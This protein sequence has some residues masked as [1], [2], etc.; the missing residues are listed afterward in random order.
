MIFA[1]APLGII[2]AYLTKKIWAKNITRKQYCWL[3][4]ITAIGSIFPD[5]DLFYY[6][7]FSAT[8]S[9]HE[10]L[11]HGFFIYFVICVVAFLS[12]YFLKKEF[13][14]KA[15]FLFLLGIFSHLIADSISA[16]VIWLAPFSYKMYG[17]A[18]FSWYNKIFGSYFFT[19]NYSLEILFFSLFLSLILHKII[20]SKKIW[21]IITVGLLLTN[22]LLDYGLYY[23][24]L[25]LYRT[26]SEVYYGD[27]D[28]DN[29]INRYDFDLDGDG[30]LNIDDPDI[31]GDGV[32]N[33][34]QLYQQ[35]K[36][37]TGIFYDPTEG[38]FLEIPLRMGLVTNVD[39]IR[40]TF[41]AQG[42]FVREEMMQDYQNDSTSYA[43]NPQHDAAFE[44]NIINWQAWL[45]HKNKLIM[46]DNNYKLH[47]G[48]ILFMSDNTA[49]LVIPSFDKDG[50]G[51]PYP[52]YK[53]LFASKE[54]RKVIATNLDLLTLQHGKIISIGR[55][56]AD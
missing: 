19:L 34:I 3:F 24:N 46:P 35:A 45:M 40:R 53:I 9:H 42:I 4:V 25:H 5:I 44:R 7:L 18:S 39:F 21:L 10:V 32:N 13:I 26:K 12:G 36:N 47:T 30:I 37:L 54:K 51:L 20:K 23:V 17:L 6:Y 43:T 38:G 27:I 14:K 31:N 8:F 16:G 33:E 28:H 29:I 49:A 48:D 56:L 15:S 41:D 1:H 11:T 52:D 55:I 2:S 50:D 22:I